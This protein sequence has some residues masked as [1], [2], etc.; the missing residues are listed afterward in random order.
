MAPS[1]KRSN[2]AAVRTKSQA[3]SRRSE[4]ASGNR[5]V[6]GA[7][8]LAMRVSL[9]TEGCLSRRP[10]GTAV[11]LEHDRGEALLEPCWELVW[12]GVNVYLPI[13]SADALGSR[14]QRA[15]A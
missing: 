10:L 3:T 6:S 12:W 11:Q 15:V 1:W 2:T 9:S 5:M 13:Q 7:C 14:G 8:P 4:R